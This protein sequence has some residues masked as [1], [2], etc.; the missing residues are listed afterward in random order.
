MGRQKKPISKNKQMI[1]RLVFMTVCQ[2]SSC[3]ILGGVEW[4][5]EL[6]FDIPKITIQN[7][8]LPLNQAKLRENGNKRR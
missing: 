5:Q 3:Q 6:N 1:R 8:Q 2:N 7:L 4:Y